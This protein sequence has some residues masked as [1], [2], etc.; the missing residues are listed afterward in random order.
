MTTHIK[1]K[2]LTRLPKH[3]EE[4]HLSRLGNT[5]CSIQQYFN[6]E[7]LEECNYMLYNVQWIN[8]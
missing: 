8:K 6:E 3:L 5:G 2:V 7:N 4:W 1:I